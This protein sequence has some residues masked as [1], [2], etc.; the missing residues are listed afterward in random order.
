MSETEH[1]RAVCCAALVH[2]GIPDLARES[3][4]AYVFTGAP[5]GGFLLAV[6]S[7]QLMQAGIIAD[8]DNERLWRAYSL[9]LMN[10]VPADC[11]GSL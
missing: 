4:L 9:I 1:D 5:L 3:I 11:H 2:A 6:F 10:H 8:P 7:N